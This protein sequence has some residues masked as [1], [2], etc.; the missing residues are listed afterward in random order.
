[1]ILRNLVVGIGICAGLF[2]AAC[3]SSSS[4]APAPAGPT[5]AGG[6]SAG[7]G[8]N[9][10]AGNGTGGS[11]TGGSG[12]AGKGGTAGAGGTGA[13][14]AGGAGG[15]DA[16]DCVTCAEIQCG[17]G[18]PAKVCNLNKP[19]PKDSGDIFGNL[20][21]CTCTMCATECDATCTKNDFPSNACLACQAKMC[22]AELKACND[23][24][25]P[26]TAKLCGGGAG[27]AAG[28]AGASGA[29]GKGG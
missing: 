22:V 3:S 10:T 28:A 17:V 29:A 19:A 1:M 16:A 18:D 24:T 12:T 6:S 26:N 23:D 7:S 25:G 21:A 15:G 4:A 14:G 8:G 13:G 11:G 2:S 9:G 20:G 5:G 27:G